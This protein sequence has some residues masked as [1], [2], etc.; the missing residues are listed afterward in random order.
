MAKQSVAEIAIIGAGLAGVSAAV[1]LH[2]LGH[3]AIIHE[4]AS[5][6]GGRMASTTIGGRRYDHGAQF[7]T[8]RGSEFTTVVESAAAGGAVHAWTNGFDDPPDGYPRWAGTSSMRDL[9]TWMIRE[10]KLDVRLGSTVEHLGALDTV[11]VLVTA[12]VPEALALLTRSD[13]L[14][15]PALHHRLAGIV[16][17]P[18]I[19]VLAATDSPPDGLPAHGGVQYLDHPDLAFVTDN[20]RK[21]VSDHPC[22][23]IH[24]SNTLSSD[25][26]TAHDDE[27]LARTREL[28]ALHLGKASIVDAT[29]IRWRY[30]G[31][32]EVDPD[33]CILF[34]DAP[35]VALA[36]EAFGD[37]KV[38]GAFLSG[39]AAADALHRALS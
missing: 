7:F 32:V 27:V 23:T 20:S 34:G 10:A 26:W 13:M 19:A 31:P 28:T 36:G 6:A 14:P 21:G 9:T 38:E 29:V 16:Y 24:L 15:E 5:E 22:L 18:T 12:P 3:T 11:A 8:T 25:L 35:I 2:K 1:R 17:K 39:L 33:R 37:P 4:A 30:A